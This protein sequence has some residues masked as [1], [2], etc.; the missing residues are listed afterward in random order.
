MIKFINN[1][2]KKEI[3]INLMMSEDLILK[4]KK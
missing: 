4:K 1:Y 2:K 3:F